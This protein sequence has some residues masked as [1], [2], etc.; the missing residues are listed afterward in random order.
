MRKLIADYLKRKHGDG[1]IEYTSPFD[2]GNIFRWF[3]D[4]T[5]YSCRYR[6]VT[7]LG[8]TLLVASKEYE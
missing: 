5:E 8:V 4:D 6:L 2:W 3:Y 1:V 7:I